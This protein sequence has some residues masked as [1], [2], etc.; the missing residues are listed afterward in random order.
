VSIT[1]DPEILS[2]LDLRD[3]INFEKFY[4]FFL[5]FNELIILV[6]RNLDLRW[7]IS[8]FQKL[9]LRDLI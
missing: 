8:F 3:F 5:A 2:N 6:L 9:E 4:E 7:K 1:P